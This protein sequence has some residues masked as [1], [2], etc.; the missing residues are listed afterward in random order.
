MDS[1][2][3][4]SLGDVP[5]VNVLEAYYGAGVVVDYAGPAGRD[6]AIRLAVMTIREMERAVDGPFEMLFQPRGNEAGSEH[7][8]SVDSVDAAVAILLQHLHPVNRYCHVVCRYGTGQA[9]S[10]GVLSEGGSGIDF[11]P[12]DRKP[13]EWYDAFW[14]ALWRTSLQLESSIPGFEMRAPGGPRSCTQG[15]R[16]SPFRDTCQTCGSPEVKDVRG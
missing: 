15:H 12:N 13:D 2:A 16:L 8:G 10:I 1:T 11:G 4:R 14:A 6:A 9:Y 3:R 5:C 7:L